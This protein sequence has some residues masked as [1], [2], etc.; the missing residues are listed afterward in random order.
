MGLP[1]YFTKQFREGDAVMVCSHVYEE[2]IR[3]GWLLPIRLGRMERHD[4]PTVATYEDG[5]ESR[6]DVTV[7]CLECAP[8]PDSQIDLVELEWRVGRLVM[9]APASGAS[10]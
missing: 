9:S 7:K 1:C 3:Q 6:C 10:A 2:N 5:S 4:P 8:K